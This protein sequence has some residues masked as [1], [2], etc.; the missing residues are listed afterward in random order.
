MLPG[1]RFSGAR[2]LKDLAN[3]PL[4]STQVFRAAIEDGLLEQKKAATTQFE[5]FSGCNCASNYGELVLA[6]RL[7]ACT[8][9]LLAQKKGTNG[10]VKTQQIRTSSIVGVGTGVTTVLLAMSQAY[11][12]TNVQSTA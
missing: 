8:S 3:S 1:D 7:V 2:L 11:E 4:Q 9:H 5:A 12:S 6:A 10:V